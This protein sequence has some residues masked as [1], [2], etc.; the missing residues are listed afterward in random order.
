MSFAIRAFNALCARKFSN[1]MSESVVATG[2][3]AAREIEVNR[4]GNENEAKYQPD[5]EFHWLALPF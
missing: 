1:G 3:S 2:R 4:K 5:D